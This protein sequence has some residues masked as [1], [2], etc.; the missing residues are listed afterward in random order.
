MRSWGLAIRR[1]MRSAAAAAVT[2][3]A[4]GAE[5]PPRVGV[6]MRSE[7]RGPPRAARGSTRTG[8]K[9]E[10]RAICRAHLPRFIRAVRTTVQV[11]TV[12]V[13]TSGDG[14]CCIKIQRT[15]HWSRRR[16]WK[17]ADYS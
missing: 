12:G 9:T 5:P 17:S 13:T 6:G 2:T 10:C 16:P 3:A 4:T 7:A 15:R 8:T 11:S 14:S 1:R